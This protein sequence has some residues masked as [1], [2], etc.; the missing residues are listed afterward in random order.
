MRAEYMTIH[1]DHGFKKEYPQESTKD[2]PARRVVQFSDKIMA[3]RMGPKTPFTQTIPH[4]PKKSG[5]IISTYPSRPVQDSGPIITSKHYSREDKK[6]PPLIEI[7]N[8][9]GINQ[10]AKRMQT[11]LRQKGHQV[12]WITNSKHFNHGETKLFYCKGYLQ[13]AYRVAKEIPGFQN[14]EEVD[15]LLRPNTKVKVVIGK[16]LSF[17]DDLVLNASPMS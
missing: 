4:E 2:E 1:A 7:A 10:M 13:D 14:M 9:N 8:G 5:A 11:Y 16:D 15:D 12:Q 6:D 17:F 3:V